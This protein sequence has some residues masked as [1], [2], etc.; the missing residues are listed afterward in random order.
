MLRRQRSL[1]FLMS[2]FHL[3]VAELDRVLRS[4][5]E[6]Q[7]RRMVFRGVVIHWAAS[8]RGVF[9]QQGQLRAD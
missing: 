4:P 3:P 6:S 5:S 1:V 9:L 8:P 7:A 2:D